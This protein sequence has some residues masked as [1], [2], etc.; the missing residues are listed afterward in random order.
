[1][2]PEDFAK[3]RK[4]ITRAISCGDI[5]CTLDLPLAEI[6]RQPLWTI[7]KN[8][9]DKYRQLHKGKPLVGICWA[10][11]QMQSPWVPGGVLRSLS[12]TQVAKIV[13]EVNNVDWVSLQF[14]QEPPVAQIISPPLESWRDTAGLISNLDAVV[15]V[16]TAVMHLADGM[17]KPTFVLSSGAADWRLIYGDIF[18]PSA[19]IFRNPTF[20]FE[21]GIDGLITELNLWTRRLAITQHTSA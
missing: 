10:A 18:Y 17:Q 12:S 1:M 6:P 19:K 7:N 5:D 4:Q 3:L 20:G 8:H 21:A 11:R 14:K 13:R 9:R 2:I 15:C 16:D